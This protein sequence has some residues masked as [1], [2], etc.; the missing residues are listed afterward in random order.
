MADKL[1]SVEDVQ[2][3]E[4]VRDLTKNRL[5]EVA[6]DEIVADPTIS[7]R[8]HSMSLASEAMGSQVRV[9]RRVDLRPGDLVF[10][11]LHTQNGAFAFADRRYLATTTFL[12]L[13]V[14]ESLVD[15]RFLFWVLH[16]RVPFLSASDTV[17][18]ETYRPDDILALRIPLPPLNEQR[19]IAERLGRISARIVAVERAEQAASQWRD[20]LLSRAASLVFDAALAQESVPIGEIIAFERGRFTPRPR[21][22]PRFFGGQHPW[23]QISEIEASDKYICAWTQTLNDDGLSV[24]R[25]F[26]A[27]TVL[28]SIAATIGSVGILTFGCCVPDSIVAAIPGS[29]TDHEFV[30]YYLSYLRSHLEDLA[31]QSAQK[32]I[33]LK[34]LKSL[35]F[36]RVPQGDQQRIVGFLDRV[37][38]QQ[39]NLADL[40]SKRSALVHALMPAVVADALA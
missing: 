25:K 13:C 40:Q 26:P 9:T 35:P 18:R 20:S 1:R 28:I 22:D 36:P 19:R 38:T 34:I 37:R 24:S 3:S 10:S 23:I 16:V 39:S 15:R 27:G 30:Y 2:L 12:P 21:N 14:N 11:R 7:S 33:N 29:D 17:G 4:V 31:P 8:T 5:R 32:N 6:P